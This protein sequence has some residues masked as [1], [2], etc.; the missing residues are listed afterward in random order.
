M[1][2][3]AYLIVEQQEKAAVALPPL[4]QELAQQHH[5]DSYQCRQRLIGR[6]LALLAQGPAPKLEKISTC[7]TA[8]GY[9]H[10]LVEPTRPEFAPQRMR[11][12]TTSSG[13]IFFRC[14]QGEIEFPAGATVLA[15][16]ADLSGSLKEQSIKQLLSSHAYRG[17]DDVRNLSDEKVISTILRG[18][19]VLDLYLLDDNQRIS[20][21]VRAL[22]GKFDPQG[23]GERAT[24]SSRQ[25]LL[26]L[27]ELVRETAGDF[28]LHTD[29]GLVNLPGCQL[30]SDP[31]DSHET[32]R[33]NLI[34]LARYGWLM[35]DLLHSGVRGEPAPSAAET[36][37][38][39][40]TATLALNP[41][42]ADDPES[43]QAQPLMETLQ[44]EID[45]EDQTQSAPAA[46]P[47]PTTDRGLPAPPEAVSSSTWR[48]PGFWLGSGGA[49]VVILLVLLDSSLDSNL[50]RAVIQPAFRSGLLPFFAAILLFGYGFYFL[51]MK[52][53][54]ENTPTSRVRSIAMGMVEVKGQARR[55]YALVSPMSHTPCVYYRL[56]KY[57]RDRNERWR[58]ASISSSANVKFELEDATGRVE[59]DPHGCRISAG[60]KQEGTPGQ[61]GMLHLDRDS[62]DKWVEE[63]I[64][65]GTLLYV[66]GYASVK[67]PTGP[68][69]AERKAEALRELKRDPEAMRYF[70]RDGDGHI[71][72]AE[73]DEARAAVEDKLLHASLNA[74]KKRKKQEEHVVIGKR[75]GHPLIISETHSEN[76]LTQ[77]YLYYSIPLLLASAAATGGAIYLFLNFLG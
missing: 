26:Q 70:D 57:R 43:A 49:A 55:T 13:G 41:A 67:R 27:M 37:M 38:A 69:R 54:M 53:E 31:P 34:S 32:R 50:M 23:L 7:L 58:I 9:R 3:P 74:G 10:W 40:M 28:T 8:I 36:D 1:S 30:R 59:I 56:T 29:F 48:K 14:R 24:L 18:A 21:A 2:S 6:G 46:P 64:V 25:N 71:S 33:Q 61:V 63:V 45:P 60:T 19:P 44:Q 73:W 65:E 52:R 17:R 15:I 20:A 76:Q 4:L 11:N 51:R 35:G 68:S 12:F 16:L 62:E 22:P 72:A 66:L 77:R 5:L 47:E 75:K 39:T 42:L